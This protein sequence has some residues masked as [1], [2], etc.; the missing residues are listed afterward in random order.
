MKK[1]KWLYLE[2]YTFI[3]NSQ[4]S[5]Y[6]YN[7]LSGEGFKFNHS[8]D[9]HAIAV[10]LADMNSLGSVELD[11][12]QLASDSVTAFVKRIKDLIAGNVLT[13]R[14]VV[15]PPML[16]LQA[17]IE[18]L[19]KDARSSGENALQYLYQ[20]DIRFAS[21]NDSDY[22]NRLMNFIRPLKNSIIRFINIHDAG[23]L[24]N[25]V[26]DMI[27]SGLDG[28]QAPK[29][30]CLHLHEFAESFV[31]L[32]KADP[33]SY[34][35]KVIISG[36]ID[37]NVMADAVRI[38]E[39]SAKPVSWE[40]QVTSADECLLAEN[41]IERYSLSV[42][43]IKP[44]YNGNNRRFFE[45]NVYVTEED[46]QT[47]ELSRRE[48]FAHQALNVNDFGKLTVTPDG[49]VYANTHHPPLGTID[50]DIR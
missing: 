5:A 39:E 19:R 13:Y 24:D 50:N 47:P 33:K 37:M 44:F 1:K 45:D 14:P 18:R 16:N 6:V 7:S 22:T 46:L 4:D 8:P 31:K 42:V 27:I 43:G 11:E 12:N 30:I 34:R 26:L 29:E 9:T 25:V 32:K 48:V 3:W 41:I 23:L 36:N 38:M 10:E 35:F 2:P 40:F 17:D 15:M 20:M 21:H 49:D 28:I